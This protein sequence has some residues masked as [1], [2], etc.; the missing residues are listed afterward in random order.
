MVQVWGCDDTL[1]L[2]NFYCKI[3]VFEF[4]SKP[5]QQEKQEKVKL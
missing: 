3:M 2:R 1:S 5:K 4:T